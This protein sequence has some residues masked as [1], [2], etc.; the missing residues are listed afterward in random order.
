GRLAVPARAGPPTHKPVTIT[1]NGV[2]DPDGDPVAI[3]IDSIRQ[4]E[5]VDSGSC[6]DAGG[7]GTDQATVL[8]E[9]DGQGDGRV[10]HIFFHAADPFGGVCTGE[11]TVCVPHDQ[12][13]G[14]DQGDVDQG[15]VN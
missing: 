10:Y 13:Q 4:D 1:V 12:G 15:E 8:V 14:D 6:S 7:V 2:I 11:V 9:R 3:T 5:P